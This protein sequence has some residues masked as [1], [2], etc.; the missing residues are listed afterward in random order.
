MKLFYSPGACSLSPHIVLREAGL[1]IDIEKVDTKAGKTASGA[2]FRALNPKGY[3]PALQLDDGSILTEGAVI[4]QY[5]ADKK[6]DG[7]LVPKA[8]TDERYRLQ[9]WLTY[10]ATEI[11]KG[12]GLLWNKN[13]AESTHTFAREALEKK[14]DFLARNLEGKQFLFG[15]RFTV[16]DAYLFTVLNWTNFLNIDLG[17]WSPLKAY[18]ERIGSRPAVRDALRAEGLL[19]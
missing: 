4:V 17:R 14:F 19:Q 13:L 2:D 18:L 8:G 12:F 16:A 9:E 1:K 6:G 7:Q 10:I 3:V 11:H 5:L 15:D